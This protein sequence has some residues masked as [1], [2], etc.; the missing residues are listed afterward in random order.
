MNRCRST[1]A[2]L[3][4]YQLRRFHSR[5][6]DAGF[7]RTWLKVWV[8]FHPQR[9][10]SDFFIHFTFPSPARVGTSVEDTFCLRPAPTRIWPNYR[11]F[12]CRASVLKRSRFTLQLLGMRLHPA[13]QWVASQRP[14]SEIFGNGDAPESRFLIRI[15]QPMY[16][17]EPMY[18]QERRDR[19]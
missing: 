1:V 9:A 15:L 17:Q 11:G 7:T 5:C 8:P 16:R 14:A 2:P 18:T 19:H 4:V 3:L 12:G 13:G 10:Q 6:V